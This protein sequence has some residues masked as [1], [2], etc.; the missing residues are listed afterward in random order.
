[1]NLRINI[2]KREKKNIENSKRQILQYNWPLFVVVSH[3][4]RAESKLQF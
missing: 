4:F 3:L 2:R 1:M